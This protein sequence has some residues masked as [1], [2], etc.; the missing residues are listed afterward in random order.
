MTRPLTAT[1]N[2]ITVLVARVPEA[3]PWVGT[4]RERF[5]PSMRMGV[6]AHITVLAPFMPPDQVTADVLRRIGRVLGALPSFSFELRKVG[7][8]AA[9]AYLAP[10][11]AT[12]FISLTRAIVAEF[13]D[14]PSY[15]GA[16]KDIVPHLTVADGDVAQA[17]L[18]ADR[19]AHVLH[20]DGPIYATCHSI[21]LLENSSGHWK[22]LHVFALRSSPAS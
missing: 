6:P 3:E 13:P 17:D 4:L 5:D 2:P 15:G 9:T 11:P 8:F 22:D 20:L 1:P 21:A 16:H 7:R 10:E 14:Y 18:A 12:P 19:L